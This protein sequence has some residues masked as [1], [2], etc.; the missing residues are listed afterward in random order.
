[1]IIVVKHNVMWLHRLT[2]AIPA[3]P[4]RVV[5]WNWGSLSEDLIWQWL[6][7]SCW[8]PQ[9]QWKKTGRKLQVPDGLKTGQWVGKYYGVRWAGGTLLK[10]V[11]VDWEVTAVVLC[12]C[13]WSAQRVLLRN[14]SETKMCATEYEI[15]RISYFAVEFLGEKVADVTC[16]LLCWLPHWLCLWEIGREGYRWWSHDC[17]CCNHHNCEQNAKHQDYNHVTVGL[18]GQPELWRL[19]LNSSYSALPEFWVVIKWEL[20]VPQ[21]ALLSL[22]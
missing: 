20:P 18:L 14:A 11:H 3:V 1:M 10:L 4:F 6:R 12:K 15:S 16:N 7:I 17:R 13:V 19:V 8:L 5:K 22:I 2:T 9:S 21:K